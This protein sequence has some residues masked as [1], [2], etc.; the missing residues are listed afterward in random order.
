R[1]GPAQAVPRSALAYQQSAGGPVPP[2]QLRRFLVLVIRMLAIIEE[3]V[4]RLQVS[5]LRIQ[6]RLD[7]LL[8]EIDDRAVVA[9]GGD[10]RLGFVG[11]GGK[12]PQ[13]LLLPARIDPA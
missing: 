7:M 13:V 10:L 5:W 2:A 9:D 12:A 4:D 6:P 11:D 3:R 8:A 1:A